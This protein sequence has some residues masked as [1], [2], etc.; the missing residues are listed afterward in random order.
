MELKPEDLDDW[1]ALT[2]NDKERQKEKAKKN[3]EESTSSPRASAMDDADKDFSLILY[4]TEPQHE[5]ADMYIGANKQEQAMS[6]HYEGVLTSMFEAK[7]PNTARLLIAFF[8]PP[9]SDCG[10]V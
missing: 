3:G 4:F 1:R 8:L 7:V 6:A 9:S 2:E 5:D 10:S